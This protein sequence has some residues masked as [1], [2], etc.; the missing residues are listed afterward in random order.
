[1]KIMTLKK[2]I[3]FRFN[4]FC[5]VRKASY[6]ISNQYEAGKKDHTFDSSSPAAKC[7]AVLKFL[8]FNGNSLS[9]PLSSSIFT[10]SVL[11]CE[12]AK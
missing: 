8:S 12:M 4:I 7:S 10:I 11:Q 3:I 2:V 9:F 1:M 5:Y 6:V